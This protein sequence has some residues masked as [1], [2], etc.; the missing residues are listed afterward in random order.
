MRK[1]IFSCFV[2]CIVIVL[3]YLYAHIDKNN[4]V[5]NR[6]TDASAFIG[7]GIVLEG[8]SISQTFVAKDNTIDGINLKIGVY[9]N[10]EKLVLQ[11]GILDS[12]NQVVA[13]AKVAGV[14]LQH[15]KFN[16][17]QLPTIENT[18]G[19][20]YTLILNVGHADE[21]NGLGFYIE[22]GLKE[23][24]RLTVREQET[25]GALVARI[26]AHRFDM[27]TFV[28]LLGILAFITGFMKVLYKFFS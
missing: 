6:D 20:Q 16:H 5:Y 26:T 1:K 14:E 24:Q 8:E 19:N 21:Q 18:K 13:E 11:Y 7:T 9:G 23:N 28:V 12:N 2:V 27:E 10:A 25:E 17:L 4:Y 3:S 22:P 15:N